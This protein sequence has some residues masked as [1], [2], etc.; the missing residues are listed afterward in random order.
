MAPVTKSL[1]AIK[2]ADGIICFSVYYVIEFLKV[3]D[4]VAAI[5]CLYDSLD[6]IRNKIWVPS[7]E[8]AINK[9]LDICIDIKES[10]S[11]KEAL[12]Q[13]RNICQQH[14]E[15][16]CLYDHQSP[17]SMT[18][19]VDRFLDA[20]KLKIEQVQEQYNLKDSYNLCLEEEVSAESILMF[21]ALEENDKRHIER[22]VI[23]PWVCFY[24]DNLR[25]ILDLVKINNTMEELYHSVC[26]RAFE[27]CTTYNRVNEFVTLRRTMHKH[28]EFLMNPSQDQTTNRFRVAWCPRTAELQMNT[29]FAQLEAACSL[30]LWS[31]AFNIM[32]DIRVIT[33]MTGSKVQLNSLYYQKLTDVFWEFH[34]YLYHAY[35][36]I[37]LLSLQKKQ[38][39]STEEELREMSSQAV[40]AALCIPMYSIVRVIMIK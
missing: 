16:L 34:N 8:D 7:T 37:K 40:L 30:K 24:W 21:F 25:S 29:R 15:S 6:P 20:C 3:G 36:Q 18:T 35:S 17:S 9:L 10:E 28:L 23:Y 2:T 19:V 14:V 39:T 32:T 31:E 1:N 5:Q 22:E 11:A 26:K 13:Y 27:F 38:G 33:N 12:S 4:K